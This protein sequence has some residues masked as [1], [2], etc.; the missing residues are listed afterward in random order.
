MDACE[1]ME[2]LI[3]CIYYVDGIILCIDMCT[4]SGRL[5]VPQCHL[6]A[7]HSYSS[8]KPVLVGQDVVLHM[9]IVQPH[10][11]SRITCDTVSI[12]I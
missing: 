5:S 11:H 1:Y 9:N 2:L 6:E 8:V 3:Q 12:L 7:V 4:S 10:P